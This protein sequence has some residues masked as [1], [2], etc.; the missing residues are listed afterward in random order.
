MSGAI[1]VHKIRDDSSSIDTI[2]MQTRSAY[3]IYGSSKLM[4]LYPIYLRS[5]G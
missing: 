1:F 3:N 4:H 5:N 2:D